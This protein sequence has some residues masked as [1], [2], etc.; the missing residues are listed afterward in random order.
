[1]QNNYKALLQNTKIKASASIELIEASLSAY[2][3]F[4]ESKNYSPKELEPYDALSDR[5][6]RAVETCIKFFVSYE[7]YLYAYKSDTYRDLLQN[8]VKVN[9]ISS[10]SIWINMRDVRNRVVHEYLPG[11]IKDMY[12]LISGEFKEELLSTKIK[13]L[14]LNIEN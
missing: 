4:D 7:Y 2:S 5:F 12:M 6:I 8:M 11:Q 10:V 1:M 14:S 9:I 3:P 13:I